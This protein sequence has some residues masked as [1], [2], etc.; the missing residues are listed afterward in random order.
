VG[1]GP[2]RPARGAAAISNVSLPGEVWHYLGNSQPKLTESFHRHRWA[3]ETVRL[4]RHDKQTRQA[5]AEAVALVE[6]GTTPATRSRLR[7]ELAAT[8][9]IAQPWLRALV[10]ELR[11]NPGR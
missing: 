9:T 5:L 8:P 6:Y 10:Q 11:R 1:S 3:D 2:A 7:R 4:P